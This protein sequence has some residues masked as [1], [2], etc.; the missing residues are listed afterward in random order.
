MDPKDHQD[1]LR[2]FKKVRFDMRQK[3]SKKAGFTLIELLVVIAI[4]GLLASIVLVSLNNAM[5]KV[6]DARRIADLKQIQ[7]ALEMFYD[8]Q[9]RYP[10][11]PGGACWDL[12]SET[13][14]MQ[15]FKNCL[16]QGANCGF[17]TTNYQPVM[18]NVPSDPSDNPSQN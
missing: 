10:Q 12:C 2:H 9:G 4:I 7:L 6:R 5:A 11:S 15:Y 14:H 8:Q 3:I 17:T 16:E 13:S 1:L 18:S